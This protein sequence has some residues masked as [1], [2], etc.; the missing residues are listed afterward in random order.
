MIS[1]FQ[2]TRSTELC[3][4][5]RKE[6]KETETESRPDPTRLD[7]TP[8]RN[9]LPT[10]RIPSVFSVL[11]VVKS[12]SFLSGC[13]QRTNACAAW[14]GVTRGRASFRALSTSRKAAKP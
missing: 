13:G 3:L 8:C 2:L 7:V 6:L 5:H 12:S 11:S 1:S 14:G 10:R 9:A 4:T